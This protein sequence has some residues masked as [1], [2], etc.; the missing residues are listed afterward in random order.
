MR[1]PV[2]VICDVDLEE[3][4]GGVIYYKKRFSDKVWDR[5]MNRINGVGHP[6]YAEWFCGKHYDRAKELEDLTIDKA[7]IKIREEE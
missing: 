4:E 6:P 3:N 1:P 5:K 7:L 2:C